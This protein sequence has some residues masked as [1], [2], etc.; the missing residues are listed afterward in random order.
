MNNIN[1]KNQFDAVVFDVKYVKVSL[2]TYKRTTISIIE[3]FISR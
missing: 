3:S 2:F 1:D